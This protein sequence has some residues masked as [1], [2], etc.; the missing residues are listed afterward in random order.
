MSIL[1]TETIGMMAAVLGTICW[2]PQAL[3]IIRTRDTKALSLGTN[4][5]MLITVTLWLIYGL[6]LSSLPIIIAN[7]V[8]MVLIGLIVVLK[9]KHG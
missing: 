9:L 8:S 5:L 6:M 4:I 1:V 2:A 7:S 3:K